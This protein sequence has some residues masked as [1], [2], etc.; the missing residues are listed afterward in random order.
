MV[1]KVHNFIVQLLDFCIIYGN[2]KLLCSKNSREILS[3]G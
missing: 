2:S 1:T 3:L